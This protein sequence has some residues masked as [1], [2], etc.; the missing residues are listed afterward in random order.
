[1]PFGP[2]S[3]RLNRAP[4][5]R[6]NLFAGPRRLQQVR[7]VDRGGRD[8]PCN[9]RTWGP[10]KKIPS[11]IRERTVCQAATST[12]VQRLGLSQQ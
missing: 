3:Y 7:P 8:R 2:L 9:A 12:I 5:P 4:I 11:C 1:M 10:T 6:P